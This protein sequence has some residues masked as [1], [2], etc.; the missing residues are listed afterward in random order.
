MNLVPRTPLNLR[1]TL[2]DI[3][4][5]AS[6]LLELT[7]RV[8]LQATQEGYSE[9]A[10]EIRDNQEQWGVKSGVSAED[11]VTLQ[12]CDDLIAD[13]DIFLPAIGHLYER[14]LDTRHGAD[15][16]RHRT[17]STIAQAVDRRSRHAPE[18]LAKYEKT[19]TYRSATAKKALRTRRRN[20]SEA[21]TGGKT[22]G[23]VKKAS[24]TKKRT[25]RAKDSSVPAIKPRIREQEKTPALSSSDENAR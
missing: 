20:E 10:Q 13:V 3:S 8:G 23:A 24:K 16:Q 14:L 22:E 21:E 4:T 19:R 17:I 12:N 15:D 11:L 2:I 5:V 9:A 18:L 1:A 25:A 7:S 6:R